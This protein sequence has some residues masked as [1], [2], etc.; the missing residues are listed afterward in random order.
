VIGAADVG[1]GHSN[2]SSR[3]ERKRQPVL[4]LIQ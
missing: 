2:P 1:G 4:N 3:V